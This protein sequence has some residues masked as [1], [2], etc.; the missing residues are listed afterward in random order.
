MTIGDK[1]RKIR[2]SK[3]LTQKDLGNMI[4]RTPQFISK[5]ESSINT[6]SLNTLDILATALDVTIGDFLTDDELP[7]EWEDIASDM[8]IAPPNDFDGTP[9]QWFLAVD[10]M[11]RDGLRESSNPK[12]FLDYYFNLLNDLGKEEAVK[13]ISELAELKKYTKKD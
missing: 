3:G 8:G 9:A 5:L 13:R 6:P 12:Y 11:H 1:I 4:K 2:I 7:G 10:A